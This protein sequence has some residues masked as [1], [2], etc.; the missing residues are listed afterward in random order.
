VGGLAFLVFALGWMGQLIVGH[1]LDRLGPRTVF[2]AAGV[3]AFMPRAL[4]LPGLDAYEGSQLRYRLD[5]GTRL[6]GQRVVVH[7][8][9]EPAVQQAIACATAGI[10]FRVVTLTGVGLKM[11]NGLVALAG[12]SLLFTLFF[13]MIASLILGMGAPT[14]ANYVITST[15][16]APALILLG[17]PVLAAHMFVFYFGIVAVV[18][19]MLGL[20]SPPYGLLLFVMQNITKLPLRDIV[21]ETMP[22]LYVMI[23]ALH[24][25]TLFP[26]SI[27]WL[28]RVF[29]YQG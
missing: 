21:K 8:G 10:I 13:T 29:G 22:F 27:L 4:K 12:G 23:A 3:G 16:A 7:G 18:N 6:A 2:I 15:I 14:T 11:A 28:P 26:D 17:V 20:I 19:I 5:E 1:F 24:C 9:D 25:I